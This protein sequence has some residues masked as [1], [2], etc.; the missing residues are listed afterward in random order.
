MKSNELKI[1]VMLDIFSG[2]P[3]PKWT[4]SNELV[5]ELKA[6]FVKLPKAEPATPPGLGYR[7][8]IITNLSKDQR[9]PDQIKV[10]NSSL[11]IV[12]SGRTSYYED[13]NNIEEWL[14]EQA[15]K[16]GYGDVIKKFREHVMSHR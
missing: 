15:R 6:K 16:L 2:R 9:I 13:V 14:L 4:L 11:T 12:E 5:D 7:G 10:Y 8:V 3:N 1:E